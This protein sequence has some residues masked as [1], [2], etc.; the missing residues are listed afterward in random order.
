MQKQHGTPSISALLV[1]YA[2]DT[3]GQIALIERNRR[4]SSFLDECVCHAIITET[5]HAFQSPPGSASKGADSADGLRRFHPR[6]PIDL[7][8]RREL[9]RQTLK[10]GDTFAARIGLLSLVGPA[11]QVT[12]NLGD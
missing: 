1:M 8:N 10:R 12:N 6:H 9:T 11:M 5:V 7:F 4:N 2:M 3:A